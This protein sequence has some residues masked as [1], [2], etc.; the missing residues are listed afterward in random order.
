MR[1][2]LAVVL[3][4][5]GMAVAGERKEVQVIES[6]MDESTY[7]I[8]GRLY[9][10]PIG[11]GTCIAR[12]AETATTYRVTVKAR[13]GEIGILLTCDLAKKSDEKHCA[14]LAPGKFQMEAK[15]N[16]KAIVYAWANPLQHGDMKKAN[17]L[18]YQIRGRALEPGEIAQPISAR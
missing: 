12:G 17:K 10:G 11:G 4:I 16:D 1:K 3:L 6:T 13:L 8:P 5:S 2:L 14:K 18:E 9:C 7:N 15:G